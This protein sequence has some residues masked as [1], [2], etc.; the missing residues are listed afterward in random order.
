[1]KR[2]IFITGG[3]GYMGSRLIPLLLE[4]GHEIRALARPG[5]E[6]KLPKG[7]ACVPGD[8]L[9]SDSYTSAVRGAD[10]FIHLIGVAHPGPA[11]AAQFR[12]IDLVSAQVAFKAAQ[13]AGIR[14]FVYLSVAQPAP[15]MKEYI[16]VRA[17]CEA[18][19]RAGGMP[20]TFLRPWYVLGPGHWWPYALIP[21]YWICQLLP[22]TRE[23]ANRLGLVTIHQMLGALVWA[24]ENPADAIRIIDVS[25]IRKLGGK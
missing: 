13:E 21:F 16:A 5:S 12:S 17:G 18:M 1:M 19:I 11:K 2:T 15:A 24:V 3:S 23:G 14:H 6:S 4:K 22:A 9:K 10:T 25:T 20:A 8:A 7:A